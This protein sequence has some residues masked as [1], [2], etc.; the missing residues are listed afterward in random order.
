MGIF[1]ENFLAKYTCRIFCNFFFVFFVFSNLSGIFN[2]SVSVFRCT[3]HG[4][5]WSISDPSIFSLLT[6]GNPL[7]KNASP[8]RRGRC[9]GP[10]RVE[11]RHLNMRLGRP[12][13][14]IIFLKSLHIVHLSLVCLNCITMSAWVWFFFTIS[15]TV[16]GKNG[17][18]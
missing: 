13:L 14:C 11:Q 9:L 18:L 2:L 1:L 16:A 17:L 12:L 10:E 3:H 8:R 5:G 15:L 6:Q 7:K 4:I